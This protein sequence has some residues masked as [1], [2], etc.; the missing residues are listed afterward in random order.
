MDENIIAILIFIVGVFT[1]ITLVVFIYINHL[2]FEKEFR[3]QY[4]EDVLDESVRS[5]S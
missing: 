5:E 4:K 3:S 2:K 1:S